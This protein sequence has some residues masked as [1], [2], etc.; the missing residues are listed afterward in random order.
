[1]P[2]FPRKFPRRGEIYW[3]PLNK[4]R[5]VVIVSNDHGNQWSDS[6]IVAPITT[7]PAAKVY[8][9]DVPLPTGDP[10]P[11]AGRIL[12]QSLYTLAKDDLKGYRDEI[13]PDQ[14]AALD[15]ALSVALGLR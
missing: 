5:P 1:M 11:E 10:L 12:C 4:V 13:T 9:T 6:V 7:Q 15:K 8:P 14:Q 3:A 2:T